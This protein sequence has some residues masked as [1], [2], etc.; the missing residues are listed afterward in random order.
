MNTV[1]VGEI[2]SVRLGVSLRGRDAT[3]PDPGGAWR[4]IRIGDIG[5]DG[6]MMTDDLL[7]FDPGNSV[8]ADH[9]LRRGD[10]LFPNRGLRTTAA[11]FELPDADVIVGAQFYVLRLNRKSVLPGYLAWYLRSEPAANFFAAR[12]KGSVV[13]TLQRRDVEEL[14]V[15]LPEMRKQAAIVALDA[16]ACE[17]RRLAAE[18]SRQNTLHLQQ[19]L[20]RA[21]TQS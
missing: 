6:A 15:P 18:L 10:V 21:A 8:K 2:A 3:R 7:Q 5:D 11:V 19:R 1:M 4:M 12:R 13:Q 16:L 17:E 20:L 14:A 9:A